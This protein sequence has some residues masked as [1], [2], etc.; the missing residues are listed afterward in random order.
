MQRTEDICHTII[1]YMR[2][3]AFSSRNNTQASLCQIHGWLITPINTKPHVHRVRTT[4]G[5]PN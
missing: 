1:Q 3:K 2:Q 4:V 5:V